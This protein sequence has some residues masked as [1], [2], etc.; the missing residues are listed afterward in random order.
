MTEISA[1]PAARLSRDEKIATLSNKLTET[2]GVH[3]RGVVEKQIANAKDA[4][5]S[6]TWAAVLDAICRQEAPQH[7]F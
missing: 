5:V 4:E 6:A 3:A 2:F 1:G 7:K